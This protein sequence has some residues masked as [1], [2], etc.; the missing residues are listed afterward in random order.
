MIKDKMNKKGITLI[1]LI[2]TIIVLLILVTVSVVAISEGNIIEKTK[3]I[4][5]DELI[6][7]TKETI[8]AVTNKV[9]GTVQYQT[10]SELADEIE[11]ELQK[12]KGFEAATVSL[13]G[14]DYQVSTSNNIELTFEEATGK[15]LPMYM[16]TYITRTELEGR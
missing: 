4:K 15:K 10:V 8:R 14:D 1:A 6:L 3:Q 2:V 9:L 5:R 11:F 13:Y 16:E 7:E 12:V